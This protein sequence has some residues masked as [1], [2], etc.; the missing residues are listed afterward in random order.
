MMIIHDSYRRITTLVCIIIT[1]GSG[2]SGH[3]A[4]WGRANQPTSPPYESHLHS[5][6]SN[7]N[8]LCTLSYD[9]NSAR[10]SLESQLYSIQVLL[11][12]L[13]P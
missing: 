7:T 4:S 10:L 6:V 13:V 8:I 9:T 12:V 11:I 1:A 3:S 2:A 5:L